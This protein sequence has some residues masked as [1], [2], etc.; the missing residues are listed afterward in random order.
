MLDYMIDNRKEYFIGDLMEFSMRNRGAFRY[1][2][3][4][5][6]MSNGDIL[7]MT[8]K[9]EQ[10][11]EVINP[12]IDL[13][14]LELPETVA[15]I[16]LR[17]E[18][19]GETYIKSRDNAMID[20]NRLKKRMTTSNRK[21]HGSRID[22]SDTQN[23][24]IADTERNYGRFEFIQMGDKSYLEKEMPFYF[25]DTFKGSLLIGIKTDKL[26]DLKSVNLINT[27]ISSIIFALLLVGVIFF[28]VRQENMAMMSKA[29]RERYD[30]LVVMSNQIAHEI[31]NPLNSLNMIAKN[32]QY[33]KEEGR[34][35]DESVEFLYDRVKAVDKIIRDYNMITSDISL[36]KRVTQIKPM[37]MT[38]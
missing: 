3:V 29:H 21:G 4:F 8:I 31:R 38:I 14:N 28:L 36:Q 10:S 30:S 15:Y 33:E 16:V 23:K 6:S 9:E 18:E 27:I 5:L 22:D 19:N 12:A 1:Y 37:M 17:D 34:V 2:L 35:S 20:I 11:I 25:P 32:I 24:N 7:T 26:N 13:D